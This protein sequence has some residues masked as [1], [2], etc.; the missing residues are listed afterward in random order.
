MKFCGKCTKHTNSNYSVGQYGIL[1][2]DCAKEY[3]YNEICQ[4]SK[5]INELRANI[6]VIRN[7][8]NEAIYS[9]CKYEF[10]STGYCQFIKGDV[11]IVHRCNVCGLE[12]LGETLGLTKRDK[13][14]RRKSDE[15]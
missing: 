7:D 12:K 5:A 4:L 13:A 1:C 3:G 6:N 8:I 10:E 2:G 9:D 11:K 14:G 15:V